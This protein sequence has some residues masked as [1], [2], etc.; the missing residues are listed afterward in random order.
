MQ[1]I[2]PAVIRNFSMITEIAPLHQWKND[3]PGSE[4][5]RFFIGIQNLY[6]VI[7]VFIKDLSVIR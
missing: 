6:D 3:M 5:E 7:L 1:E 2:F 4:S